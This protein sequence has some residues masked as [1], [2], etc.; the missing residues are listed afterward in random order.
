MTQLVLAC[1]I[2][3]AAVVAAAL[4]RQRRAVDPPSQPRSAGAV[5]AQLD[6]G[7]FVRPERPWLVAVFTSATCDSCA[8]VW[9]KAQVMDSADVA[10]EEV[11][12]G[13]A[14][15]VHRRYAIDAVPTVVIADQAGVVRRHFV[16]P[17]T[18][19]D[20]WAALAAVRAEEG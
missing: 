20:L 18:A 6:R 1:A 5:P 12:Y 13:A 16:G 15:D 14:K 10:V 3:A 4:L 9:Q 11:E 2:V 19:T 17:V 8:L 7:D